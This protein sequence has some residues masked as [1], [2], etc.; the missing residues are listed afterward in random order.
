M[1]AILHRFVHMCFSTLSELKTL[2][3]GCMQTGIAMQLWKQVMYSFVIV[4][5][6]YCHNESQLNMMALCSCM[7]VLCCGITT[8]HLVKQSH[9]YGMMN[10]TCIIGLAS[11]KNQECLGTRLSLTYMSNSDYALYGAI[12]SFGFCTSLSSDFCYKKSL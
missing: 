6:T 11:S 10:N 12:E 4:N 9:P 8:M 1:F 2:E 3:L 7:I 5:F